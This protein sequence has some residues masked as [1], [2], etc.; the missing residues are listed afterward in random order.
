MLL[1]DVG[2]LVC[3]YRGQLAFRLGGFYKACVGADIA[4][5]S[6]EG[7]DLVV[8]DDE[9][10]KLSSSGSAVLG[11]AFAEV[12][13]VVVD[14]GVVEHRL[15]LAHAAHEGLPELLLCL[16]G[17]HGAGAGAEVG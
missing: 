6:G 2:D 4:A 1:G 7:V 3:E 15:I 17:H 14:Q 16:G 5:G 13:H 11:Q 8:V 12:L 10:M 9:E